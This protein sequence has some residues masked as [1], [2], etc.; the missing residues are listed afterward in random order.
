MPPRSI[1][2]VCAIHVLL[3]VAA[4]QPGLAADLGAAPVP[5][6]V[7][8]RVVV[9][10]VDRFEARFGAFAHFER[11]TS[12]DISGALVTPRLLPSTPGYL[13]YLVPRVQIGGSLNTA[14]RTSFGYADLLW[15]LPVYGPLFF[16]PFVGPAVHNGSLTPTQTLSGLG[17]PVLF[18]AGASIGYRV[19]QNWSVIATFEH[20]SNGKTLFGVDCGTNQGGR[21]TNQGLNNYG[22][23]LGYAF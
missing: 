11:G 23:R 4:L 12:V 1:S 7:P 9:D 20:L 2:V 8:A 19:G 17:C 14:G 6:G 3:A 10:P 13:G 16:E 21:G 18:H 15:T 5:F 22:V